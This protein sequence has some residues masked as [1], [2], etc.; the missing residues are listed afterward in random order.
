MVNALRR[1][2]ANPK[3]PD[4]FLGVLQTFWSSKSEKPQDQIYALLGFLEESTRP[5]DGVFH[6]DYERTVEEVFT[7]V[8][9]YCIS[10]PRSVDELSNQLENPGQDL[11][12]SEGVGIVSFGQYRLTKRAH[13][14]LNILCASFSLH[15]DPGWPSWLP[16]WRHFRGVYSIDHLTSSR[17]RA[18]ADR[19]TEYRFSPDR[20]AI[21]ITGHKI[22]TIKEPSDYVTQC[23]T[24]LGERL[25]YARGSRPLI[26]QVRG[27]MDFAGTRGGAAAGAGVS[28]TERFWRT[29]V[30]DSGPRLWTDE[31]PTSWCEMSLESL[32][33]SLD[34]DDMFEEAS[35]LRWLQSTTHF[36][37]FTVSSTN[38]YL[39]VPFH[40]VEG[41]VVCILLGCDVPVVLREVDGYWLWVGDCFCMDWMHGEVLPP[42]GV[43]LQTFELH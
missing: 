23:W 2:R 7:D 27:W 25:T 5:Y 18:S 6:V 37:M 20:R 10:A 39:M 24:A 12:A 33:N 19:P 31:V 40:A 4:W 21:T 30:F 1:T 32:E 36:R 13:G 26:K 8:V 41:D 38:R 22:D 15:H 34:D 11:N 17:F 42:D 29:L 28:D 14:P 35:L 43:G 3:T 9:D 16:D